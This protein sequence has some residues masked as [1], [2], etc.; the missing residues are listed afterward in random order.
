MIR[1]RSP[2]GSITA[3]FIVAVHQRIVQFCW[4]GVTGTIAARSGGAAWSG[5]FVMA[6]K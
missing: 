3:A 6:M 4:I 2:P 5:G 1:G